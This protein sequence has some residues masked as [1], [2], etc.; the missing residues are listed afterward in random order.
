FATAAHQPGSPP[1]HSAECTPAAATP[2]LPRAPC[3]SGSAL[4]PTCH[5]PTA[6][7]LQLSLLFHPRSA[8]ET[9]QTPTGQNTLKSRP[10]PRSVPWSH[11]LAA[12]TATAPP[13]CGARLLLPS[14]GLS[15]L[16]CRSHKPTTPAGSAAVV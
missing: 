7:H 16:T 14:D 15:S 10:A 9:A 3:L 8:A 2:P 13:C 5:S 11:T 4:L 1:A 12:P 6:T